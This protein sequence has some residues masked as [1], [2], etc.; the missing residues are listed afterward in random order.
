M[1]GAIVASAGV[2][3]I[4]AS[5]NPPLSWT[6]DATGWAVFDV[7]LLL[8]VVGSLLFGIVTVLTRTHLINT[9]PGVDSALPEST[10]TF[11]KS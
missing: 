9:H 2:V 5:K 7:G 8:M 6:S 1:A 4:I 11:R 3:L 10:D